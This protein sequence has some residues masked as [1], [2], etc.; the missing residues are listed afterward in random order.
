MKAI[1]QT[2]RKKK[3]Y[4]FLKNRYKRLPKTIEIL[5]HLLETYILYVLIIFFLQNKILFPGTSLK[6]SNSSFSKIKKFEINYLKT[7]FGKVETWFFKN[8]NNSLKTIIFSH[9]NYELIDNYINFSIKYLEL[10]FNILLVEYP[11]Y[12][13]SD[14]Y[15]SEKNFEETYTKAFD[16]LKKNQ[17]QTSIIEFR[18]RI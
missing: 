2:L 1:L 17:K 15:P 5:F 6:R 18:K 14:G 10:N 8:K 9:G 12:G 11:G 13:D 7:A 4:L 3:I 16:W